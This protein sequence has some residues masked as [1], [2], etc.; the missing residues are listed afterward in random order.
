MSVAGFGCRAGARPESLRDAFEAAQAA[1]LR[2]GAS[3]VSL[4]ATLADKAPILGPLADTLG[5]PV[6]ALPAAELACVDTPTRSAA[7]LAA[8]GTGSVAEASALAA[9]GPGARLAGPRAVSADRMATC[10]IAIRSKQ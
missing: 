2:A 7:S 10:A 6:A 5:L 4:L 8:R 1:A 3:P 9:A